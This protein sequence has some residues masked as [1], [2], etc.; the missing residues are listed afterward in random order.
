MRCL[1][2]HRHFGNHRI[3]PTLLRK[4]YSKHKIKR[5]RIKLTKEIKPEKEEEYELWRLD[6][7]RRIREL[8]ADGYK[9]I[10]LDECG[11]TT[12]TLQTNDYTNK[13]YKHRI[14]MV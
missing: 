12:K 14:P 9:I 3:N 8:Q 2:F 4:V 13:N 5:K 6:L 7:K 10:Y 1:L 11:L